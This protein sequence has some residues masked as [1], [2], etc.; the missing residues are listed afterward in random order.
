MRIPQLVSMGRRRHKHGRILRSC[1]TLSLVGVLFLSLGQTA[2]GASDSGSEAQSDDPLSRASLCDWQRDYHFF[3]KAPK[4]D[5]V[6]TNPCEAAFRRAVTVASDQAEQDMSP[7][8]EKASFEA[9]LRAIVSGYPIEAMVP[10]IAEYDR[11]IAGLIVGIAKKES[12]WG[13]RVPRTASGDD[14]FNYWGYK[15][16]GARGIAMG[17]GCFGESAEAVHAIGGRLQELTA[18]RQTSEPANLVIWKC[19]SSCAGHSPESVRKWISDVD[20]YFRAIARK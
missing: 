14:C 9:E 6:E 4:A 15:G 8:G 3:A 19:G 5:K 1:Q 17:H 20:L 18:L 12:N 11:D 16:A 7:S 10:V 13:K 2:D